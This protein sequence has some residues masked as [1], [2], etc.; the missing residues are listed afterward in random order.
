MEKQRP[1]KMEQAG[2]GLYTG[3]ADDEWTK[4]TGQPWTAHIYK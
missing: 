1:M 4:Y 2:K 3:A